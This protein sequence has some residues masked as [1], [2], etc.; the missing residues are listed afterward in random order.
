MYHTA[1]FS[2]KR[3]TKRQRHHLKRPRIRAEHMK[4]R[5]NLPQCIIM[6]PRLEALETHQCYPLLRKVPNR[7]AI[8]DSW[9]KVLCSPPLFMVPPDARLRGFGKLA[10]AMV[11]IACIAL[12][13]EIFLV[14]IRMLFCPE[15]LW[16]AMDGIIYRYMLCTLLDRSAFMVALESVVPN[17][18][19]F[20][21]LHLWEHQT[22]TP[23]SVFRWTLPTAVPGPR[24]DA[25]PTSSPATQHSYPAYPACH[26][27]AARNMANRPDSP[28]G[29]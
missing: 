6:V 10:R 1:G 19:P 8:I 11:F 26:P 4:E 9:R 3:K 24:P 22:T 16:D 21:T 7:N 13:E 2:P 5:R 17:I 25:T 28:K 15:N 18:L 29:A 12:S 27:L 20:P 23:C 14:Q